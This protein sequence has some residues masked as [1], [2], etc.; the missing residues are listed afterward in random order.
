MSCSALEVESGFL[1]SESLTNAELL[2]KLFYQLSTWTET[3]VGD[4]AR[5]IGYLFAFKYYNIGTQA[6]LEIS[7]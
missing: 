1:K 2:K 4:K 5:F 6:V 3:S 7:V